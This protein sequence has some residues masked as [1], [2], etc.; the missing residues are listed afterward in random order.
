L[1]SVTGDSPQAG[2]DRAAP[3]R[4]ALSQERS[5]DTRRKLI[6]TALEIW[7]ERGFETAFEDT[8][9]E[10]IAR[11]AGVSKGTFY[12]H[13]AHKE[14]ILL[15]MPWA[16]AE[17]MLDEAELAIGWGEGTF[18]LVEQLMTSLARR[19]SRAPRGALLRVVSHWSRLTH[20]G[21]PPEQAR[22]FGLAF[23]AVMRYAIERG[24][25]PA[26][27]EV[28]EVAALLQ[29]A[30]MDTLVTWAA[31]TQ[32]PS[33]LRRRL[34]RRADIVLCGAAASYARAAPFNTALTSTEGKSA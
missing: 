31:T 4:S 21:T 22:G 23:E 15:E 14:D 11:A 29:A 7:N 13:F 17:I 9:A 5:R 18:D 2:A 28:E 8:T 12:F 20:T 34:C 25:L 6:R 27:V 33:A 19:V 24:D 16:T 26:G 30:T 10:E 32:T 1:S 3:R